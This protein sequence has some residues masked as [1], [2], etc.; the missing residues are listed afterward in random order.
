MSKIT[1]EE[2]ENKRK[3]FI[4]SKIPEVIKLFKSRVQE[5]KMLRESLNASINVGEVET[6]KPVEVQGIILTG[7]GNPYLTLADCVS[8]V[9]PSGAFSDELGISKDKYGN[10]SFLVHIPT[11][12]DIPEDND[13]SFLNRDNFGIRI[14]MWFFD[15][16]L[17]KVRLPDTIIPFTEEQ[18]KEIEKTLD[19]NQKNLSAILNIKVCNKLI[20]ISKKNPDGK[21]VFVFEKKD[22]NGNFVIDLNEDKQAVVQFTQDG[23]G[24]R[25]FLFKFFQSQEL[26]EFAQPAK[27]IIDLLFNKYNKEIRSQLAEYYDEQALGIR[28][29]LEDKLDDYGELC[30]EFKEEYSELPGLLKKFNDI[31]D[32]VSS[33]QKVSIPYDLL[34]TELQKRTTFREDFVI[35]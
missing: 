16:N 26:S 9:F 24:L 25:D 7:N 22:E 10:P 6:D 28:R 30:E 32:E 5:G 31:I 33:K 19:E 11:Y 23:E 15:E 8:E 27:G 2:I 29:V 14:G 35:E 12:C 17:M 13:R 3:E 34:P 21:D 1:R 18:I 4:Q 20:P